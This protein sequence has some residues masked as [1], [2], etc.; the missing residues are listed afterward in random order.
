MFSAGPVK[1]TEHRRRQQQQHKCI[2]SLVLQWP[3]RRIPILSNQ[4]KTGSIQRHETKK[5]RTKAS[6]AEGKAEAIRKWKQLSQ[7]ADFGPCTRKGQ[8]NEVSRMQGW[9]FTCG[10]DILG[11]KKACFHILGTVHLQKPIAHNSTPCLRR[12]IQDQT[13]AVTLGWTF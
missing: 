1:S 12:C 4:R 5:K 13:V 10:K 3:F 7:Q 8:T 9:Y 11:P 6:A 2:F